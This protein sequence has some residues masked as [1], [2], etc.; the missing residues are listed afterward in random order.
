VDDLRDLAQL[1]GATA[2]EGASFATPD[3]ASLAN[4]AK[5]LG[6]K[7]PDEFHAPRAVRERWLSARAADEELTALWYAAS[8]DLSALIEGRPHDWT[9]RARRGRALA[10]R[11]E[12]ASAAADYAEA[13][14]L[15]AAPAL[16]WLDREA[17][18]CNRAGASAPAVIALNEIISARPNDPAPIARR[19][20]AMADLGQWKEAVADYNKAIDLGPKD[21]QAYRNRGDAWYAK[22]DYDKAIADYGE[23]IRLD[24]KYALP[25]YAQAYCNRGN[26][27]YAKQ[28]YDKAIADYGEA[29]RLDPKDATAYNGRAWLWA[30]CPDEKCRDGK[31]AIESATRACELTDWKDTLLFD[32]LAAAYAEAGNFDAAVKCQVKALELLAKDD[33]RN[34]KD[35]EARLTLYRAK[36]PYHE[37]PKTGRAGD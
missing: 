31:R 12:W 24:P 23:A 8:G 25:K 33:E 19:G 5:S 13:R 9:L 28:D 22:Q 20:R 29:I 21:A 34:R 4:L 17:T 7:F 30:T 18:V 27:W 15:A 37:E 2:V 36:K 14:R 16:A 6:R 10:A 32:T 35:F 11:G 1:L 3:G 26:A